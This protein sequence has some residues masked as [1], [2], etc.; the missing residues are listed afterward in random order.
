MSKVFLSHSSKDKEKYVRKVYEKLKKSIGSDNIIIDEASF[1]EGRDTEREIKYHLER[2]D[3]FVIFLSEN[4]LSSEWV[5]SEIKKI[6]NLRKDNEIEI[7]PIIIDEK[8]RYD[9]KRIPKWMKRGYNIQL[10]K[11]P[12][13]SASIIEQRMIEISYKKHPRLKERETIFV[14]RHEYR[15][16]IE[17]RFDDYDKL[18]PIVIIVSGLEGIGRRTLLKRAMIDSNQIKESY[19]FPEIILKE[20]ESIEDVILK[21]NDFVNLEINIK[22]LNKYTVAEKEQLFL[23]IIKNIQSSKILLLIKDNGCIIN[24]NGEIVEWFCNILKSDELQEMATFL[25]ASKFR[26]FH[27]DFSTD[28]FYDIALDE[29]TQ[30]ERIGLF[31]RILEFENMDDYLNPED[32]KD[33]SKLLSGFPE[34]VFFTIEL[35]KNYQLNQLKDRYSDIVN[36]NKRK[37]TILLEEI[38]KNEE[39]MELLALLSSFDYITLSYINSIV[40][41]EITRKYIDEFYLLGICEYSGLM[42]EYIRVNDTIKDY[43]QRSEYEIS[44]EHKE[45]IRQNVLE[46]IK[47]IKNNEDYEIP[48]FLYNLKYALKEGID[49]D[50]NY[51]IPS[52]YLKTMVDLYTK[53]KNKEVVEFAKRALENS[54]NMDKKIIFEIRYLLCSSLAKMKKEEFKTEIQKIDGAD[55]DFL[56]GF[57]YRKV[58]KFD[59]ALERINES[60]QDRENF[61]KAKREKVQIHIS[62]QEY[63]EALDLAK[64]NYENSKDN[65]YHIQAYFVCAIKSNIQNKSKILKELIESID[66]IESIVAKEMTLRMKAEYEA[67]I[68]N[69]YDKAKKLIDQAIKAEKHHNYAR[70][71]KFEIAEKFNRID[72]MEEIVNYF[73]TIFKSDEFK[74]YKEK[75]I[76]LE[77][78]LKAKKG[79][80]K[81]RIENYFKNNVNNFTENAKNKFISRLHKIRVVK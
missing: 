26:Y 23:K 9:D 66:E 33:I 60:L 34:Q 56:F 3:L 73:K 30:K 79:E 65:P 72:E 53:G 7:C 74:S 24:H 20:D 21:L 11:A 18:T 19:T 2:T 77:C 46:F 44:S 40:S 31:K 27:K 43:I 13:K 41:E 63:E 1:Q 15:K 25:L 17:E 64:M 29:L 39:K 35:L 4:S 32:I 68:N 36:F 38:K 78:I 81:K 48:E 5:K 28:R 8:I 54:H 37:A 75:I 58:G 80:S 10:I 47:N 45:K 50:E 14:G 55:H 12:T 59:K 57:Y 49:I 6:D 61:S 69:N 42:K 70:F 16:K 71:V 62:M 52:V 22:D 76:C 51:I 67:F